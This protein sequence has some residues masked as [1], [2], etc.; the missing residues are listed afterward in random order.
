MAASIVVTS[1]VQP[2]ISPLMV[3]AEHRCHHRRTASSQKNFVD[4]PA[5]ADMQGYVRVCNQS[6]H[7]HPPAPTHTHTRTHEAEAND[8][9]SR[10]HS[11]GGT[12]GQPRSHQGT[13]DLRMQKSKDREQQPSPMADGRRG[14]ANGDDSRAREDSNWTCRFCGNFWHESNGEAPLL[15]VLL[16]DGSSGH[17]AASPLRAGLP[18]VKLLVAGLSDWGLKEEDEG[19]FLRNPGCQ[20]AVLYSSKKLSLHMSAVGLEHLA[21]SVEI[22][23]QP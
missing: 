4:S 5:T 15:L 23:R 21:S 8:G 12:A 3:A 20:P 16:P 14:W 1:T 6:R 10:W 2:I 17:R 7:P 9:R 18:G 13:P 22:Q 11:S 19:S